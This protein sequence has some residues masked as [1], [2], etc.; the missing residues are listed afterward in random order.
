MHAIEKQL[1][2]DPR[3]RICRSCTPR[4]NLLQVQFGGVNN[5]PMG[6]TIAMIMILAISALG[7]VFLLLTQLLRRWAA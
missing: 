1:V 7:V 3:A 6:A 2:I 4:G 5:W